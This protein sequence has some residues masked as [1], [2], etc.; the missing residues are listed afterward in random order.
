[1]T[2][3]RIPPVLRAQAGNNKQVEVT[4]ST[5]GEALQALIGEFPG[6]R[7]QLLTADGALNR[8][9]NVYVN[10]RDV[11]YEQEL[12][13]P[14][15]ATRH[16][17][18]AA[19][20]GRRL[21]LPGVKVADADRLR[22]GDRVEASARGRRYASI[23]DAIGN[24]PLVEI[25]RMSPNPNVRLYAK[26]EFMN[27]TGSVKDRVAKY[28]I[29]DLERSGRLGPDS[30]IL[31]PTSGNTGIALAMIARRKG[32]RL[33]VV[34]PGE[35]DPRA[36]P[37]ADAVR[38]GDHRSPGALGSNGAVALAKRLVAEDDRYVMPYQY[39]NPANPQAHYETTAA[40]IIEDCPEVDVFVGGL[41]TGGT[42]MGIGQASA[43]AQP[44]GAHLR[45][46]A[47]PGRRRPGPALARR[48]LHPG[49]LRSGHPRREASSS[50]TPSPS[51]R[52]AT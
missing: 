33:A 36:P 15:T 23:V 41:G 50:P 43:R 16:G 32:Y 46:R 28:L 9:V 12:A 20:H 6:L 17:D 52:C 38:R 27:P 13:T 1:M 21:R 5:V 29:E 31:E 44:A 7:D 35:R 48:G 3:V 39:G 10:G 37:A 49:D 11:R 24:T 8:F 47:A 14:V 26:L 30:I 22:P 18:P 34:L 25:A 42:L 19:G 40:E 45:R 4:G 2:A 51:T